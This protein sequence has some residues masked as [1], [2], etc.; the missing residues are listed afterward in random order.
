[1]SLRDKFAR[2]SYHPLV[3]GKI[4]LN[5]SGRSRKACLEVGKQLWDK[6]LDIMTAASRYWWVWSVGVSVFIFS[7]GGKT[8]K[9]QLNGWPHQVFQLLKLVVFCICCFGF[10]ECVLHHMMA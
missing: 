9:S 4:H 10:L 8:A 5:S 7:S 2:I 6:P 1:M 3:L